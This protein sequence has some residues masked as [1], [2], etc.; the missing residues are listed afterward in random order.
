MRCDK[1]GNLYIARYGKG[2]V[3][4]LS[5]KGKLI[6]EIALKGSKPTNVAFGG[7]HRKTVY[8]TLQDRGAVEKFPVKIGGWQ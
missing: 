4:V 2:T 1:H 5:K 3:A 8:V 6:R 7:R